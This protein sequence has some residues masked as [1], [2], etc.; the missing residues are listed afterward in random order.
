[1]DFNQ[2]WNESEIFAG[3]GAMDAAEQAW[4]TAQEFTAIRCAEIADKTEEDGICSKKTVAAIRK[5]F[6][7]PKAG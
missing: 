1:M 3:E 6:N 5:E 4:D 7:L 2:W